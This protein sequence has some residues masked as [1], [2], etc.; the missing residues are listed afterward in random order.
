M[1]HPDEADKIAMPGFVFDLELQ[2]LRQSSGERVTLRPQTLAVLN[3]LARKADRVVTKDELMRAVWP[4]VV[5]TD[6]SLVQCVRDLRKT[7]GDDTHRV[8]QTEPRRGYRLVLGGVH[9]AAPPR[10][11]SPDDFRQDIRFATS[12][13]GIR[14][15]YAT[16]GSGPALVRA[17][18]WMTHL[19]WDW[20]SPVYGQFIQRLSQRHRLIR[21]D[22]RGC[23]LS[24]RDV[25]RVTLEQEVRDLEAVVDDAGLDRFALLGRSQ[26]GAIAIRYAAR[27][28]ER[29]SKLVVCGGFSRGG[30]RRGERS[31]SPTNTMA[32]CKLLE[33][34]WGEPT[35]AFRQIWTSL[36]YPGA[37]AEQQDAFNHLQGVACSPKQAAMMHRMIVEFDASADLQHVRCPTLVL[38][39]PQDAIVPFEEGRLIAS[40]I[41]G[42]RLESFSSRNHMPLPEEPAFD[43]IIRRIDEFLLGDTSAH[44]GAALRTT[45]AESEETVDNRGSLRVVGGMQ[46]ARRSAP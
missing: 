24:D 44:E 36:V 23:G 43:Q 38:H 19:D 27:H 33:D 30:Q 14:I 41:P 37:T 15:A 31:M 17:P 2:E 20:Q 29:V 42:A 25:Q 45:T 13:E 5:V 35:S 6:D 12:T 22:G 1:H 28:P 32:F 46:A 9:G 40:T 39:N 11:A 18:H 21:Y 10:A 7:L 8:V 16:S 3:C 34:G 26:G 4:D